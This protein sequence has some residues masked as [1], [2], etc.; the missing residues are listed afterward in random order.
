MSLQLWIP[1][2]MHIAPVTWDISCLISWRILPIVFYILTAGQLSLGRVQGGDW[3]LLQLILAGQSFADG[4]CSS[5]DV[6]LRI[7]EEIRQA[8]GESH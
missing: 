6:F 7:E 4:V 8:G 2:H 5:L 1:M 3:I